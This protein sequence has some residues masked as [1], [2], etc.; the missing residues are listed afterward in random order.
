MG[1]NGV[2]RSPPMAHTNQNSR[3]RLPTMKPG[4]RRSSRH[5]SLRACLRST[6]ASSRDAGG[7]PL[8]TDGPSGSSGETSIP[9]GRMV[10]CP[11]C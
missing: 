9:S 3:M 11:P 1:S 7:P 2:M 5:C 6:R 8:L 10:T 4:R